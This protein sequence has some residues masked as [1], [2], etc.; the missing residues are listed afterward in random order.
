MMISCGRDS[1]RQKHLFDNSNGFNGMVRHADCAAAGASAG[2]RQHLRQYVMPSTDHR[3]EVTSG[4][5]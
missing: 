5:V 2:A 4:F 1:I 3:F